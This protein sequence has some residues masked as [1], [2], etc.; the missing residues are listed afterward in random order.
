LQTTN[1]CSILN[2]HQELPWRYDRKR[3]LLSWNRTVKKGIECGILRGLSIDDR[4]DLKKNCNGLVPIFTYRLWEAIRVSFD[5]IEMAFQSLVSETPFLLFPSAFTDGVKSM[6][7]NGLVWMGEEAFYSNKLRKIRRGFTC[8]TKIGA[9]DFDQE[10]RLL[11][12]IREHFTRN[13]SK[14]AN[15]AFDENE[16]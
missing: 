8:K 3:N 6:V 14:F 16:V 10:L 4:P 5:T 11:R 7:I 9:I 2:V 12:F 1:T 15:G 13:K